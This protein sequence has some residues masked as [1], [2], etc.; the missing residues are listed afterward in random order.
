PRSVTACWSVSA[1]TRVAPTR[2]GSMRGWTTIVLLCGCSFE[3]GTAADQAD[4]N[5]VGVDAAPLTCPT[6]FVWT[7]DFTVDPTTLNNNAGPEPD[8]R[9]REGGAFPGWLTDG[10]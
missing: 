4:A 2:I 5:V 7:A 1:P 6:K 10:V 8:W 9:V 3:H